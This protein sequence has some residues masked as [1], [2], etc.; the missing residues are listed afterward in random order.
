MPYLTTSTRLEGFFARSKT[1]NKESYGEGKSQQNR[2]EDVVEEDFDFAMESHHIECLKKNRVFLCDKISLSADFYAHLSQNDVITDDHLNE[3]QNI[4]RNGTTKEAVLHLL[5]AI[6]PKR[7]LETFGLFLE[8]LRTS[9]QKHVAERLDEWLKESGQNSEDQRIISQVRSELQSYYK[10]KLQSIIPMPWLKNIQLSLTEMC[11]ERQLKRKINPKGEEKMITTDRL[12]THKADQTIPRRLLIEGDPGIGKSILCQ[13]LAFEWSR[14]S[15]GDRCKTPCIHCFGLTFYLDARQFMNQKTVEDVVLKS[16][17]LPEDLGISSTRMTHVIKAT[18]V[19]FI[20]DGYDEVFSQNLLLDRLI[21]GK[22]FRHKT[23]LLTS[24]RNFL[25]D[26]INHFDCVYLIE[27]YDEHQLLEHVRRFTELQEIPISRLK[28]LLESKEVENLGKNPLMLTLLCLLHTEKDV[29]TR[30]Q[31][32]LYSEIHDFILRKASERMELTEEYVEKQLLRPLS[33]LAFEAFENGEHVLHEMDFERAG[34]SSE[35]FCEVGYLAR[36]ILI[37]GIKQERRYSFTHRTFLEFL[38]AKHLVLMADEERLKWLRKYYCKPNS[39]RIE[40]IQRHTFRLFFR[41]AEN[42]VVFLFPLLQQHPNV[43]AQI[44]STVIDGTLDTTMSLSLCN[45]PSFKVHVEYSCPPS[46]VFCRLLCELNTMPQVLVTAIA[47]RL[48]SYIEMEVR[49]DC[50]DR[51]IQGMGIIY[52]LHLPELNYT[53]LDIHTQLYTQT[54]I[55]LLREL[56]N[57]TQFD[58]VR[59]HATD[60]QHL[61]S[62][63]LAL[64][65]GQLNSIKNVEIIK[66]SICKDIAPQR[67]PFG[68]DLRGISLVRYDKGSTHRFLEIVSKKPLIKLG[69]IDCDLDDRCKRC[70][71]NLLLNRDLQS[72]TLVSK[73]QHMG[74]FLERLTGLDKLQNLLISLKEMDKVERQNLEKILKKNTLQELRLIHC[75]YFADLCNILSNHFSRM[76]TLRHLCVFNLIDSQPIDRIFCNLYLLRLQKFKI[77]C[78]LNDDNLNAITGAIRSWSNLQVLLIHDQSPKA[79]FAGNNVRISLAEGALQLLIEA[80]A[81]C[82]SLKSLVL[83]GLRIQDRLIPEMCKVLKSLIQLKHFELTY[84]AD[85][86]LTEEGLKPLQQFVDVIEER[87]TCAYCPLPSLWLHT[88]NRLF[89]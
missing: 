83:Y 48:S 86:S 1:K 28:S 23:V 37:R 87:L 79:S 27:G 88:Y 81:S 42:V 67:L 56:V 57:S 45:L 76:T 22:M 89:N 38:A 25:H 65:I 18:N 62:S 53:P 7:R 14:Q 8:A 74:R 82:H 44:A 15:C 35:E 19:L 58:P 9:G 72:V 21:K 60:N 3:I 13:K 51:C 50:S 47:K 36:D 34:L 43:Q 41:V 66:S 11:V 75:E 5:T 46:H 2:Y 52:N 4:K 20:I 55:P 10:R 78:V 54:N 30:S 17:L 33:Q 80:I 6:L 31:T 40:E 24:R 26:N 71:S 63:L 64:Q 32:E 59:I 68:D 69:V 73:S 61:N 16:D 70:L 29:R 77:Q 39:N 49:P 12:F 84:I 85:G